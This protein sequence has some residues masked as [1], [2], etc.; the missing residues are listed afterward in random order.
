MKSYI[1]D[2]CGDEDGVVIDFAILE[3]VLQ[4]AVYEALLTRKMEKVS[5]DFLRG[6]CETVLGPYTV[7][8]LTPTSIDFK[9]ER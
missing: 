3:C 4:E 5:V 9:L 7:M 6:I 8:P 2:L 1:Q